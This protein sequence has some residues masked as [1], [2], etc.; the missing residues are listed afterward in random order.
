M[1]WWMPLQLIQGLDDTQSRR[2]ELRQLMI[3]VGAAGEL[4]WKE[5]DHRIGSAGSDRAPPDYSAESIKD[6]SFGLPPAMP[7]CCEMTSPSL[8][9]R[10][11]G[12]PLTRYSTAMD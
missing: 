2:G 3:E 9:T 6:L 1:R 7:T 11:V 5:C 8:N 4:A 12:M 10:N